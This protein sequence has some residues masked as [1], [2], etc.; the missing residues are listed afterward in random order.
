MQEW[1]YTTFAAP[2]SH[3]WEKFIKPAELTAILETHGLMAGE[4]RGIVSRRNPLA[5]LLDFYRRAQGKLSFKELGE[6]LDF[7][8]SDHLDT[9]YMGYATRKAGAL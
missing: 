8:E 4:M 5:T 7:Q 6:R 3:V 2:N 9:S 1:R